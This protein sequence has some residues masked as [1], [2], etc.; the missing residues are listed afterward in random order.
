LFVSAPVK[1]PA[2]S[3]VRISIPARAEAGLTVGSP[4]Q[5]DPVKLMAELPCKIVASQLSGCVVW[6][7]RP[8]QV[9]E[10]VTQPSLDTSHDLLTYEATPSA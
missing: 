9:K 3:K 1:L 5:L 2:P 7:L 4:L 6:P 10:R 8:G